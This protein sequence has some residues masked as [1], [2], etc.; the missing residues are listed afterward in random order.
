MTYSGY[1][2]SPCFL[3][4]PRQELVRYMSATPSTNWDRVECDRKRHLPAWPD[5]SKRF[6]AFSRL[7][8]PLMFFQMRNGAGSSGR[9]AAETIF[10]S[11]SL[12][13]CAEPSRLGA[14][15][16]TANG[17]CS[18]PTPMAAVV[19]HFQLCEVS[20]D[21]WGQASVKNKRN[22]TCRLTDR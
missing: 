17:F 7:S 11:G 1:P 21:S 16:G 8:L 9:K 4:N 3:T 10:G 2:I 20:I 13:S 6:R 5:A 18:S 19:Y 15:S 14:T 12:T 22:C